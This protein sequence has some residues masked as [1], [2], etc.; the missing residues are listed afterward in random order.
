MSEVVSRVPTKW[1]VVGWERD[2]LQMEADHI[3][4]S[5]MSLQGCA[6]FLM[7]DI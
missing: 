5:D 2:R 7:A 4:N 6:S 1:G 3:R